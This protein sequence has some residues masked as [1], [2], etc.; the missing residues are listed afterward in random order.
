MKKVLVVDDSYSARCNAV[1]ALLDAGLSADAVL[2]ADNGLQGLLQLDANRDIALVL[3]D[4]GMPGMNGLDFLTGVRARRSRS[5]LP[6]LMMTTA[7]SE[8][9]LPQALALGA[10]GALSAPLEGDSIAPYLQALQE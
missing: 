6:V 3:S 1:Q 5:Q 10:N 9:F 2:Q 8:I 7:G 4:V